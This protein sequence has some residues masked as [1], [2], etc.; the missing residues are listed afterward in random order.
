MDSWEP[1]DVSAELYR[2]QRCGHGPFRPGSESCHCPA[3]AAADS[4]ELPSTAS[5]PRGL[6]LE[7]LAAPADTY[8][9]LDAEPL[10]TD[11]ARRLVAQIAYRQFKVAEQLRA[12]SGKVRKASSHSALSLMQAQA[13]VLERTAK[14]YGEARKTAES[15]AT[16]AQSSE[17]VELLDRREAMVRRLEKLQA[18]QVRELEAAH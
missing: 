18:G 15:A 6:R 10:S 16:L 17:E 1:A 13:A 8:P 4:Q 3:G 14:A 11:T 2:C 5:D 7:Q 9:D 12:L